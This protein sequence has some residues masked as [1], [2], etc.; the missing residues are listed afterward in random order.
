MAGSWSGTGRLARAQ[1][2]D[3][4]GVIA[5]MVAHE[6]EAERH[7]E[8]Y[9]YVSE[10]R[11]ERTGGHLWRELVAETAAGKVRHLVAVDGQPLTGEQLAAE[12]ARMADIAAHPEAFARREQALKNDEQH[13]KQMLDL[14]PKAFLFENPRQEGS[15]LRVDFK[16]NPD[17]SPQSIEERI[18]HAMVGSVVVETGKM[19]LRELDG[20]LPEDVNIAF[21]LVATIK[22]GSHFATTRQPVHTGPVYGTEWKTQSLDTDVTGRAIFFKAI[23]KKEHAEHAEFKILPPEISVPQAVELLEKDSSGRLGTLALK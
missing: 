11:S 6:Y 1:S 14:L 4:K 17:Y 7:R 8:R 18:L 19:R 10:E 16:P 22:A 5:S 21:G 13:A 15:Y 12:R 9:E 23:G 3:P 20:R 2:L